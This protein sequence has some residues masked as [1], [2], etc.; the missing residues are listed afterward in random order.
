MRSER[1]AP[2][3]S[4]NLG[5]YV[6][7]SDPIKEAGPGVLSLGDLLAALDETEV[8]IEKALAAADEAFMAEETDRRWKDRYTGRPGDVPLLP[9]HLSRRPNRCDPPTLRQVRQDHLGSYQLPARS[10]LAGSW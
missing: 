2:F 7:E 4:G 1:I 3:P 5:R 8:R 9:R 6:Q 10:R